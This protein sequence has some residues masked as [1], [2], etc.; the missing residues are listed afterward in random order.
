MTPTRSRRPLEAALG[1]ACALSLAA[2]E[3][4]GPPGVDRELLDE[5]VSRAVGDPNTCVLIA[6]A[7]SGKLLYRYNTPTVCARELPA[8]TSHDLTRL[9]K[10][11]DATARDRQPRALSCNTA[12]D[13]SRGVGWAAGPVEGTDMVYAALMEGDRAFPGLM[14][15]DRLRNAF[16]KAR[17][18][19]PAP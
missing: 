3:P 18:S 11:L 5:A 16:R 19:K 17:L 15:A 6:R 9:S 7:G 14:M 10:V 1:A 8:C 13:A 4:S 2:C 12:A